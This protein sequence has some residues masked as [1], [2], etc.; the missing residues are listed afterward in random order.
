[1]TPAQGDP[2]VRRIPVARR[3]SDIDALG[4]VNNVVFADYLQEARMGLIR[5]IGLVR[6]D[7]YA[8]VVVDLSIAFRKPL[9]LSPEPLIVETWIERM[10]RTSYVIRYRIIDE[11]GDVAAE[12][13]T[14][15]AIVDR[16]SGRPAR[17][18]A[19][20]RAVLEPLTISE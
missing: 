11:E 2:R 4:H 9:L 16:G 19:E 1:M 20:L 8:Q 13:S 3:F 6:N 18:D 5:D 7:D 15:L 17:M 12:A 14:T 10:L